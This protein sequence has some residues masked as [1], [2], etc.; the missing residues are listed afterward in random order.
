MLNSVKRG[1]SS[2][3]FACIVM[4]SSTTANAETQP[5]WFELLSSDMR[6][7]ANFYGRLF[8]WEV[9]PME[10]GYWLF[11]KDGE[12]IGAAAPLPQEG[13]NK[14]LSFWLMGVPVD[15]VARAGFEAKSQGAKILQEKSKHPL[16]GDASI[17]TDP[18][19]TPLL[20]FGGQAPESQAGV[21]RWGWVELW[22]KEVD[23]A[24]KFYAYSKDVNVR[25]YKLNGKPYARMGIDG[26]LLGAIA[27]NP[28]EKSPDLWMPFVRVEDV[29]STLD[30]AAQLGGKVM[31]AQ[32]GDKESYK[33]GLFASPSG[34]AM[35]VFSGELKGESNENN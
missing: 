11:K 33:V 18:M 25:S 14:T 31:Y 22:S 26:Q 23:K 27:E 8:E 17:I 7:D 34:A 9:E 28:M 10:K 20:V 32:V 13:N 4:A 16:L 30:R 6:K 5:Y 29:K 12:T 2:L 35:L 15:D 21:D 24:I 19:G 1:L 3:L